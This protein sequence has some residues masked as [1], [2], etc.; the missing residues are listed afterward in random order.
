M[1]KKINLLN[2]GLCVLI[3]FIILAI[4][5]PVMNLKDPLIINLSQRFAPIGTANHLLGTDNLGRDLLSRLIWGARPSLIIGL[6]PIVIGIIISSILGGL[7]GYK[8]GYIEIII[9]RILDIILALP[10]V[11]L[12]ITIAAILGPGLKNMLFALTFILIPPMTRVVYQEIIRT[13]NL[14]FIDAAKITGASTARIIFIHIL[15]NSIS[16]L[17]AYGAS[18]AGLGIVLGAGLSFIGLGIQPPDPDWGQTINGGRSAL[19]K[20]PHV[21]LLP[22]LGILILSFSFNLIADGLRDIN[23]PTQKESIF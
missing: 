22:G 3:I 18:V 4:F 23:S 1:A 19:I 21:A 14:L 10:P 16:T 17:L 5:T 6:V 12:A 11:F 15:P 20:A 9:M 2:I 7:A 13:S 8:R